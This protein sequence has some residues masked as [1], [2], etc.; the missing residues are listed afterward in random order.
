M[1]SVLRPPSRHF[2]T[3]R[4]EFFSPSSVP[5]S[6]ARQWAPSWISRL[7]LKETLVLIIR[8]WDDFWGDIVTLEP[9]KDWVN[10]NA[11][12]RSWGGP[13]SAWYWEADLDVWSDVNLGKNSAP[14]KGEIE[15]VNFFVG[16]K[17]QVGGMKQD[18]L[19]STK[20]AIF[21]TSCVIFRA[22]FI[23]HFH[24]SYSCYVCI[25]NA[26]LTSL[27]VY[28]FVYNAG[29]CG[30]LVKKLGSTQRY[31]RHRASCCIRIICVAYIVEWQVGLIWGF[32]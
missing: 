17:T 16:K 4:R 8:S 24:L 13:T 20:L 12:R 31:H 22:W 26:S 7:F 30:Y 1:R 32:P 19:F 29:I 9:E 3:L 21:D 10:L 25:G 15:V 14:S 18:I 5:N 2:Q 28:S 27:H 11:H 23:I 6:P